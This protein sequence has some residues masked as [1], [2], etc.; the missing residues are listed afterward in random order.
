MLLSDIE[1]TKRDVKLHKNLQSVVEE[2]SKKIDIRVNELR[3]ELSRRN[4]RISVHE[5]KDGQRN[6][7]LFNVSDRMNRKTLLEV[8]I[9]LFIQVKLTYRGTVLLL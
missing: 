2:C 7:V 3:S 9:N 4:V 6:I 8:V 5:H 1:E